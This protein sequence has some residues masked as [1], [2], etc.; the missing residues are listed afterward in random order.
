MNLSIL[1]STQSFLQRFK[2]HPCTELPTD[3]IINIFSSFYTFGTSDYFGFLC[4]YH[5]HLFV[6]ASFDYSAD[7]RQSHSVVDE[8]IHRS[9]V[10]PLVLEQD[11]MRKTCM[12]CQEAVGSSHSREAAALCY[13]FAIAVGKRLSAVFMHQQV[14]MSTTNPMRIMTFHSSKFMIAILKMLNVRIQSYVQ[15]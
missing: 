4:Y 8:S 14:I 13:M 2:S 7:E 6:F 3:W 1:Q 11:L 5:Y 9:S 10:Q 12:G 15:Y